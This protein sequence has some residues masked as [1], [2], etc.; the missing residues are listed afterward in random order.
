MFNNEIAIINGKNSQDYGVYLINGNIFDKPKRVVEYV[1]VPGRSGD[2]TIDKDRWENIDITYTFAAYD[3]AIE[4]LQG[5]I[6]FLNANTGY[7]TIETSLEPEIFRQGVLREISSPQVSMTGGGYVDVVFNCKPQKWLRDNPFMNVR[8]SGSGSLVTTRVDNPTKYDARP[9][10]RVKKY[11]NAASTERIV[12]NNYY[13]DSNGYIVKTLRQYDIR[14]STTDEIWIDCES[15]EA[16][17]GSTSYNQYVSFLVLPHNSPATSDSRP[18]LMGNTDI[19]G[20]PL[21][22]ETPLT[23]GTVFT[24][25]GM[26]PAAFDVLKMYP[27]WWTI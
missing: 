17:N 14:V 25:I 2:L 27:R 22:M 9:L 12:F 24:N 16:Y 10:L 11:V 3:N 20:N 8:P 7:Q 15:G 21:T 23:G 19:P 4:R 26:V 18:A 6:A 1:S 13:A 5:W